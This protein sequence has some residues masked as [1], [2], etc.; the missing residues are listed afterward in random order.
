MSAPDA[1]KDDEYAS[2]DPVRMQLA[3]ILLGKSQLHEDAVG[4]LAQP[5]PVM[6][7]R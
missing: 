7:E 5:R 4:I 6:T 1:S 2:H 3:D